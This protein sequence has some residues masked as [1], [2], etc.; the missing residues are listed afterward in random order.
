[1]C[2]P[3]S[4]GGGSTYHFSTSQPK[5]PR[6]V[7]QETF[8]ITYFGLEGILKSGKETIAVWLFPCIVSTSDPS[9]S[10]REVRKPTCLS[11]LS[12]VIKDYLGPGECLKTRD[13][14][15]PTVLEAGVG[16]RWHCVERELPCIHSGWGSRWAGKHLWRVCSPDK[17]S[18]E[19]CLPWGSCAQSIHLWGECHGIKAI[20][21]MK[22]KTVPLV[23]GSK[24]SSRE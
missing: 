4:E 17:L 2:C 3:Q 9:G 7:F 5:S 23:T 13:L 24:S 1:M 19:S 22:V 8:C 18:W 10:F 16:R 20:L 14:Y 11:L 21:T 15:C 12:V 6:C